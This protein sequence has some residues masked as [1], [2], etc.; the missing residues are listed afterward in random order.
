MP[1][2]R[3]K[4][5]A[6]RDLCELK[7]KFE[8]LERSLNQQQSDSSSISSSESSI[9]SE[10]SRPMQNDPQQEAVLSVAANIPVQEPLVTDLQFLGEGPKASLQT[11]P[12]LHEELVSRWS[13]Y[14]KEGLSP[15]VRKDLIT[16]FPIP[17]NCS[18]LQPPKLNDEVRSILGTQTQKNDRYMLHLQEQM[19]ASLSAIGSILNLKLLDPNVPLTLDEPKLQTLA[20]AAQLL[21]NSFHA[22]SVKRRLSRAVKSLPNVRK[23]AEEI[24]KPKP[25]FSQPS[26][27]LGPRDLNSKR[28]FYK[29]RKKRS[30]SPPSEHRLTMYRRKDPKTRENQDHRQTQ[31]FRKWR[32]KK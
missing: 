9:E 23:V 1:N 18:T 11:G 31:K 29:A 12:A 30:P 6:I 26:T 2:K 15:E 16:K 19:G 10:D 27:S 5:K 24:K 8:R 14:L 4:R 25:S 21:A 7:R 22:I 13:N 3:E 20:E 28:P 17:S 32:A